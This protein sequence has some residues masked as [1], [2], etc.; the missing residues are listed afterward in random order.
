MTLAE[1]KEIRERQSLETIDMTTAEATAYFKKGA[2]E[3]NRI[4]EEIKQEKANSG[5]GVNKPAVNQ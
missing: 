4:I 3:I 5:K 1:I 2:D